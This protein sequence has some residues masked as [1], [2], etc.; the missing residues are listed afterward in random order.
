MIRNV[1]FDIGKVLIGFDWDNYIGGLFDEETG[2]HV[3]SAMFGGESWIELDRGVMSVDEIVGLFHAAEPEYREQISEAFRRIGE[4]VVK[5]GW[6]SQLIDSIKDRGYKVYFLSNMSEHV[7]ASNPEAFE[8]TG[9]MDGGIFSCRVK[10]VK[11][12]AEIFCKLFERYDLRPEECIFIDDQRDNIA[13]AAK[14]GMK[15]IRFISREQLESDLNQALAKDKGHDR[16]TVVCY[17]DSNTYGFD[18][19]TGG[20][21]PYDSRWTTI[22]GDMLGPGYEVIPEGLN[23]RTTAYDRPGA[24]WKNGAGSF[25]A[26]LG[27]H[28]P[29][30]VLVIMLG[31]ND[32]NEALGLSAED[33]AAGMEKLITMAEAELPGLQ[34]YMPQI[35]ISA[36]AAIREDYESS[37]FA[38]ELSPDSVRKSREIGRLYEDIAGRHDCQFVNA[39]DGAEVS[40]DCE[41]LSAKGHMQLAG[42]IYSVITEGRQS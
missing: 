35:V 40:G 1:V 16:L 4:C 33:I 8:F 29:V 36:P 3:S 10:A 27:T 32:C 17:G 25:I 2:A 22:L 34:G 26:C 31:T 20:R 7:L 12:D 14:L 5:R 42:M 13:A 37:P 30:D 6:A 18:P 21:Y 38:D 23:G 9:H 19:G 28:K 15:P 24:E 41:H 39:S 11:P